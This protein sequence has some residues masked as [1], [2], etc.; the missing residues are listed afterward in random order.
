MKITPVLITWLCCFLMVFVQ[1]LGIPLVAADKN[2]LKPVFPGKE[3]ERRSPEELGLDAEKLKEYREFVGGRGCI[4]RNG[5]LV[6]SWGEYDRP[7]D[8]ASAVK[9][10]YSYLMI[11]ALANGKLK[12]FDA[13]V[14]N[15]WSD[16]P[17]IKES[18]GHSDLKLTFRHFGFQTACLGF[19]EAPGT[20]FDY[21]D[22][23][24][25]FFWDTLI[26]KVYGVP[27]EEAETE[28]I[29]PLISQPLQFQDGTPNILQRNTGRFQVSARDFCRFGLLF[30]NEGHWKEEQILSREMVTM[31]ISEPLPLSI[32]RTA[33]NES[34][35]VFPLRSIGGRGNQ[36]D[37]NGGY[38]WMWWLNKTARDGELW[39]KDVPDNFYACFGHGGREG[40]AILPEQGIIVSWITEKELH[41]DRNA[42]NYAFT[43]LTDSVISK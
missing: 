38:S 19:T 31:A 26:N 41:Q 17:K 7:H 13:P 14:A 18:P 10:F 5:Y 1:I 25:G 16:L 30:L 11:Q 22:G 3:W 8:V 6:E 33:G 12:S 35:T 9:P 42:G 28:V 4:V 40:M 23:T 2:D 29:G 27:W 39:F 37:H 32:P 36:C 43:L 34:E 20:A 15:Y 21:N 24:M